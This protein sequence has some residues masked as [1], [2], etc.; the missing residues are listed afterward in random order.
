MQSNAPSHLL[1]KIPSCAF[2]SD[3]EQF[4]K[5]KFHRVLSNWAQDLLQKERHERRTKQRI[6]SKKA[7]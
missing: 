7:A 5:R 1:L 2:A 6:T 3:A 4:A